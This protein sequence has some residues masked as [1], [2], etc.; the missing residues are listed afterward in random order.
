MASDT[1]TTAQLQA[2]AT[3]I[4]SSEFSGLP[5]TADSGVVIAEAYNLEASPV[6]T[7]YKTFVDLQTVGVTFDGA[8]LG[9]ITSANSERLRTF[10]AWVPEGVIPE[11]DDH[12]A[13]YNDVFSGAAGAATRAKLDVLWV[14]NV[15]RCERLYAT[16]TGTTNNPGLLVFEGNID[17]NTILAAWAA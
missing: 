9:N 2:L 7:V 13:F 15:T 11:R 8:D 17:S 14:K 12:R 6:F 10:A 16:G 4:A 3:D 1:L 5:Q